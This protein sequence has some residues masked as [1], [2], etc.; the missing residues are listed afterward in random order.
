MEHHVV[1]IWVANLFFFNLKHLI[2]DGRFCLLVF[3][4]R[5]MPCLYSEGEAF[6][7]VFSNSDYRSGSVFLKVVMLQDEFGIFILVLTCVS[8]LG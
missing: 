7:P 2:D 5:A 1:N 3:F 6:S 8:L 4:M